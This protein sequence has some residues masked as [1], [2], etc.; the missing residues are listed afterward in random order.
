MKKVKV[1]KAFNDK[2][3]G[4][5]TRHVNETFECPEDRAKELEAG[6]FVKIIEKPAKTKEKTTEETK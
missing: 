6:S 3:N 1:I 2:I 5:I 4:F